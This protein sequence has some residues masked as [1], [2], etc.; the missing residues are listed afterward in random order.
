MDG[1]GLV[2]GLLSP[3]R[4]GALGVL[5]PVTVA[6]AADA[7]LSGRA[8]FGWELWGLMVLVAWHELRVASSPA[9][10]D[11]S[12]LQPMRVPAPGPTV[13]VARR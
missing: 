12:D 11:A 9:L 13:G 5:D 2:T 6:G 1:R 4:V 3:E 8:A 7:H 10:P